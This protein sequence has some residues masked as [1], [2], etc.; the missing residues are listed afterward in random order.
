MFI[1]IEYENAQSPGGAGCLTN[2]S[3]LRSFGFLAVPYY[4]HAAPLGLG[5]ACSSPIQPQC[6]PALIRPAWPEPL[7]DIPHSPRFRR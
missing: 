4:K 1:V 7:W 5:N 3:L 6:M 2:M